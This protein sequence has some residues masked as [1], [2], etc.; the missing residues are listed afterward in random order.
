MDVPSYL[1]YRH[2]GDIFFSSSFFLTNPGQK[3]ANMHILVNNFFI[4]LYATCLKW[5]QSTLT[6]SLNFPIAFSPTDDHSRVV[7]TQ[8]DGNPCSDY[9]NAS[10]IDVS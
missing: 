5:N 10:Y 6:N 1:P 2:E 9:V 8:L 7:L 3:K 4:T